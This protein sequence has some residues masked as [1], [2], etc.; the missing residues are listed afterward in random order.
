MILMISYSNNELKV[1]EEQQYRRNIR[2]R[3]ERLGRIDRAAYVRL[4]SAL[5]QYAS[6]LTRKNIFPVGQRVQADGELSCANGTVPDET[7]GTVTQNH[8]TV[9]VE[10]DNGIYIEVNEGHL[11]ALDK[12]TQVE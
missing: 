10:F 11:F 1:L 2:H 7:T 5:D 12:Q 6:R 4:S 9:G 3:L 8:D